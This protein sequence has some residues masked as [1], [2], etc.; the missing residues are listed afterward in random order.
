MPAT[1]IVSP[2]VVVDRAGGRRG[3]HVHAADGVLDRGTVLVVRVHGKDGQRLLARVHGIEIPLAQ[4]PALTLVAIFI[5][6][7]DFLRSSLS[8]T[9]KKVSRAASALSRSDCEQVV[10]GP[11]EGRIL[12]V[13]G[14]HALDLA[15]GH[16]RVLV[17]AESILNL[18]QQPDEAAGGAV[19]AATH[20]RGDQ[21]GRVARALGMLA[22]LMKWLV[23]IGRAAGFAPLS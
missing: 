10:G 14:E 7:R 15:G 20:D 5:Q 6:R 18:G 17:L 13:L 3:N 4:A 21:L 16:D 23:G 11:H 8:Q 1:E 2:P 22:Q 12:G 19:G 9:L